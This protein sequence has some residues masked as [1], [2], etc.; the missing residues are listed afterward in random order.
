MTRRWWVALLAILVV[1]MAAV[2]AAS[3][4]PELVRRVAIARIHAATGRPVDIAHVDL[5]LLR[6]RASIQG[7][8]LAER[9]GRPFAAVERLD[10]A[11]RLPWLL[12]G[13]VRLR[14][15]SIRDSTVDVVRMPDGTFNF[16]D[17]V[18]QQGAS[19]RPPALTVDHFTLTGGKVTLEDRAARE[20]TTWVSDQITIEA[21]DLS[22][23]G[24]RGRATARSITA[25]A[26]VAIELRDVRLHPIRVH[27]TVTTEG[28][29]LALARA[30]MAPDASVV[31]ERGR[32]SATLTAA[33]DAR[34]GLRADLTGRFEDVVIGSP[35][36]GEPLAV[37]PK[38]IT[39]IGGLAINERAFRLDQLAVEGAMNVRDPAA[40][41]GQRFKLSDVRAS[42]TNLTWPATTPGRVD[43]TTSIPGGGTLM[44][45]GTVRP[46]SEA[47]DIHVRLANLNLVPWGQL[48]PVAARI[49]GVA[50]ADLRV[51]E[52]LAASMPAR[53][54]G[55]VAVDR[56]G[57]ADDRR[58]II[59]ARRIEA[60]DIQLHWD[61]GEQQA[62]AIQ[63]GRVLISE[64]RALVERDKAGGF[65]AKDLA[66][67][68]V[69]AASTTSDV[70]KP[71]SAA[72]GRVE[73]GEVLVRNGSVS[74]RD[75]SVSP[76]A[77]L[78]MAA[79][80]ARVT[81]IG[82]PLRGPTGLRADLRPPGGGRLRVTGRVGLDP[83]D[84]DA[85]V[86]A[87]NAEL[88][89]Y[90]PYLPIAAQVAAGALDADLAVVV[91]SLTEATRAT[92]RGRAAVAHVDVRDG[93]RT[94]MRVDRATATGIDIDWPDRVVIDRVALA[95]PWLLIERDAKGE[96]PL[97]ALL[98]PRRQA[99]PC[100]TGACPPADSQAAAE[101]VAATIA[102]LTIDGGGVR[103]VDQKVSP[104]FAVD[105][106]SAMVRIDGLSTVEPKPARLELSSRLGSGSELK[107]RGT[108][109]PLAGP[110]R[111]D[112]NGEM[113]DFALPRANPYVLQYA[114]WKTDEGR[115]TSK[116]Q[117]RVNGDALSAKTDIRLSRLHLVR[118]AEADKAQAH[119]G[120]PLGMVTALMKNKQGD[121]TLSLPIGGKLS[122]P[123]FDLSE[124]IW[125][126]VRTVAVHAITL[127]VSWIGRVRFT[128]D[129]RI[130]RIDVDPV[131]FEGAA[132]VLS[133]AGRSQA[134]RLAAFLD[135]LPEVRVAL[136][137]VVSSQDVAEFKRRT[138]EAAID[139]L[140]REHQLGRDA[141][142]TRLFKERFPDQPAP[143]TAGA[144]LGALLETEEIAP[145][146]VE[147]LG[148]QRLAAVRDMLTRAGIQG[149]R[150]TERKLVQREARDGQVDVDILDREAPRPSKVRE[151]LRRFGMPT[152]ESGR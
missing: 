97:R 117:C 62:P 28:L 126:A 53:V 103:V 61:G 33:L 107:L 84:A 145:S 52:P 79:V 130:E 110:L 10:V 51:N 134:T 64:P 95:Q 30:Y 80:D 34:E 20:P 7:L 26:P 1:V 120:L 112:L 128:A 4:L 127:P 48:L 139:R 106:Q 69:L 55:S 150:L 99:V 76:P 124:T 89:P 32:V 36:G 54:L 111:V 73:I 123:R 135:E 19:G 68:R 100:S 122:D 18:G 15:L 131:T 105:L 129:S 45:A 35:G 21:H 29:D 63:I 148:S 60:S 8:R 136:T 11:L 74:W 24:D 37:A 104:P 114:G 146:E 5:S 132:A 81:G 115:L 42:V 88:A 2:A 40:R 101:P 83:M 140:A 82:W 65:P 71:P 151:V 149:E 109:G 138:V 113:R 12:V 9:D 14:E 6:G 13:H 44:V 118:A 38:I 87:Q 142:A 90:R 22:T 98:T 137:P 16:S 66:R 141:A 78:E 31:P 46:A 93:E 94:V 143:A 86:V 17:L 59:G 108:V 27:A 70:G 102:Q 23:R 47:S 119:I 147:K 91:P 96:L 121:I 56:F 75:E 41:A 152:K 72:A 50:Q 85:R 144:A 133:E 77:R 58:E 3:R 43:L 49:S 67:P 57:V 125:S 92:A 39:R 25:G 116:L